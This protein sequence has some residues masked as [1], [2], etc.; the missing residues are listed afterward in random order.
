MANR[1]TNDL[2]RADV[3]PRRVWMNRRQIL[4]GLAGAG[5]G[6]IAGPALA[7]GDDM[8]PNAWDDITGYNNFY[9]FGTGKEDP[10]RHAGALT[11]TPWNVRIDGLVDRPGD[12]DFAQIMD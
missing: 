6:A 3:T 12:Y 10:A 7:S 11:T 9:E 1:W 8:E 2:T 4:A 5:I